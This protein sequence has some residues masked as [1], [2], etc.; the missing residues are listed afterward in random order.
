[1]R[2]Q[3]A[4]ELFERV[5]LFCDIGAERISCLNLLFVKSS[6]GVHSTDLFVRIFLSST[7][8]CW[9]CFVY[10]QSSHGACTMIELEVVKIVFFKGNIRKGKNDLRSYFFFFVASWWR[11]FQWR[12]NLS[13]VPGPHSRR[14]L[15]ETE[16]RAEQRERPTCQIGKITG[17]R[18]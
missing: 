6:L 9:L 13:F 3:I 10:E 18:P 7:W 8:N 16:E 4:D 1:M 12:Q 2:R 15:F 17:G 14:R 11:R 5:W